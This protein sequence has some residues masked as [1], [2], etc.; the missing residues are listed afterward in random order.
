MN[1]FTNQ[2]PTYRNIENK[3]IV[4]KGEMCG[5]WINWELGINIHTLLYIKLVTNKD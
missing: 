2:K 1:L 3:L 4:T 5:E